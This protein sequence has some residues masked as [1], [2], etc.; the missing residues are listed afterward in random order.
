MASSLN[1][2]DSTA[3]SSVF[4]PCTK[5]YWL[6][7]RIWYFS[8]TRC[9]RLNT[10]PCAIFTMSHSSAIGLM[11]FLISG[12]IFFRSGTMT[13]VWVPSGYLP[14]ITMP[15]MMPSSVVAKS[16]CPSPSSLA[17]SCWFKHTLYMSRLTPSRPAA[18]P[19]LLLFMY[20]ISSASVTASHTPSSMYV[21]S[22]MLVIS[23]ISRLSISAEV[24]APTCP[25]ASSTAAPANL[26]LSACVISSTILSLF[27]VISPLLL[28]LAPAC[29]GDVLLCLGGLALPGT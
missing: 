9:T 16:F 13:L 18:L 26:V 22:L 24:S 21:C 23:L 12:L 10:K 19:P 14:F 5:P 6:L 11:L 3:Q 7:L 28:S 4:L 1:S 15:L 27:F 29:H 25:E 17:C 20:S 8:A 2:L